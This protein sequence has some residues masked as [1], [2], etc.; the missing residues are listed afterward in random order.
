MDELNR[1]FQPDLQDE[2]LLEYFPPDPAIQAIVTDFIARNR[3]RILQAY[4][5]LPETQGGRIISNQ[6]FAGLILD[7]L[8][9][10]GFF[11]EE[12]RKRE[13][14]EAAAE[15]QIV[16][17]LPDLEGEELVFEWKL[18]PPSQ[19]AHGKKWE[20][21]R[22]GQLVHRQPAYW[23]DYCIYLCTLRALKRRYGRRVK[24]VIP[25][26]VGLAV[27]YGDDMSAPGKV[28]YARQQLREP[29]EGR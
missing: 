16:N 5:R 24:D 14:R 29:V 3:E 9:E 13:E 19:N 6:I 21:W 17:E 15:Q 8:E 23:E 18:N 20:L 26:S 11:E 22:N 10:T 4:D 2:E 28:A 1:A 25:D 27:M 12:R 7:M